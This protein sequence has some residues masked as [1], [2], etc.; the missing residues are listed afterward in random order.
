ME[1]FLCQKN[2]K[3]RKKWIKQIN[4]ILLLFLPLEL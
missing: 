4:E 3:E 1:K 2:K